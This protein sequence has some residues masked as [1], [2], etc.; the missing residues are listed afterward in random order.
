MFGFR[1]SRFLSAGSNFLCV[2]TL[3]VNPHWLGCPGC[4][5]YRGSTAALSALSAFRLKDPQFLCDVE[6]LILG[7]LLRWGP[8]SQSYHLFMRDWKQ[9]QCAKLEGKSMFRLLGGALRILSTVLACGYDSSQMG[10][11]SWMEFFII[12]TVPDWFDDQC[13]IF[14]QGCW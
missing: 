4:S 8:L 9:K 11:R 13:V 10:T 2:V 1:Y 6:I 12:N 14:I 3:L 5:Q 7:S